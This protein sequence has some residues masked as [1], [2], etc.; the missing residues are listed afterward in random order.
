M[1]RSAR[2]AAAFFGHPYL[3][4][5]L[6]VGL[7]CLGAAHIFVRTS[8]YGAALTS[9][10]VS[11][12]TAAENLAAGH[13]LPV[14]FR[15]WP[16][17]FPWLLAFLGLWASDLAEVGRYLNILAFGLV[18]V[19]AGLWLHRNLKSPLLALAT[20]AVAAA[21]FPL[22]H[23]FS[24]VLTES[25][26]ILY[27]LLAL[28]QA[29]MWRKRPAASAWGPLLVAALLA[30]AATVTRY[31]GVTLIATISAIALGHR[32]AS[33]RR[34]WNYAFV[35]NVVALLPLAVVLAHNWIALGT[36][37][38]E[39]GLV[40]EGKAQSP[41]ALLD[42]LFQVFQ[43]WTFTTEM[44]EGQLLLIMAGVT[45]VGLGALA[46]VIVRGDPAVLPILGQRALLPFGLFALVYTA[47]LVWS[48]PWGF[49]Q[50]LD[51]RYLAPVYLPVLLTG[52]SLLDEFRHR[53]GQG[54]SQIA[55]RVLT[56]VMLAPFALYF[57][58]SVRDNLALTARARAS[59]Y[60]DNTYNTQRWTESETLAFVK[61]L[62]IDGRRGRIYSNDDSGVYWTTG[63]ASDPEL[64][65]WMPNGPQRLRQWFKRGTGVA[66]VI[67]LDF[68]PKRGYERFEVQALPGVETLAELSD[69]AVL[70]VPRG[71]I[72]DEE[73]Y[74]ANKTRY[75]RSLMDD[76]GRLVVRAHFNVYVNRQSNRLTYAKTPCQPEDVQSKFILH[77]VPAARTDLPASRRSFGFNNLSFHFNDLGLRFDAICMATVTLPT[78]R[79]DRIR[80]GQYD[81]RA[82]R[83]VWKEEFS[84]SALSSDADSASRDAP[85]AAITAPPQAI[86]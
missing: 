81:S 73:V 18:L 33:L 19:V 1:L 82:Q 45:A 61:A 48:A 66:Y 25:L 77:L 11:Y 78:Y 70:R 56:G 7:G 54:R 4:V 59:G 8:A 35:F 15:Y 3:A 43:Q 27:L 84:W 30:G 13:G 24:Y 40:A 72:I 14:T 39:R 86:Q 32:K 2:F 64:Y 34:R 6:H 21:S 31:V 60:I 71:G 62:G 23:V 52:A 9:D 68:M 36:L 67:W 42:Q 12:I 53:I 41:S 29:E 74:Q 79:I 50:V 44:P 20:T 28:L 22:N 5:A 80:V 85:I 10:S 17:A 76:L 65:S 47:F 16:P 63:R 55:Q 38:G 26:F 57:G 75:I 37:T 51:N 46:Y 49:E 69:G 83:D 58:L